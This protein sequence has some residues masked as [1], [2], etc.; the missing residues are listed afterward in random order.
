MNTHPITVTLPAS[1]STPLP[2]TGDEPVKK[3][4]LPVVLPQD[5][6]RAR[7]KTAGLIDAHGICAPHIPPHL[8]PLPLDQKAAIHDWLNKKMISIESTCET[9]FWKAVISL[10]DA[11]CFFWASLPC[12]ETSVIGSTVQNLIRAHAAQSL[13]IYGFLNEEEEVECNDTDIRTW[14][15]GDVKKKDLRKGVK[16]LT[17]HLA[18]S[19]PEELTGRKAAEYLEATYPGKYHEKI[20]DAQIAENVIGN[21]AFRKFHVH[22]DPEQLLMTVAIGD[23]KA[24]P[25]EFIVASK[26]KN[27]SLFRLDDIEIDLTS[28]IQ[29]KSELGSTQAVVDFKTRRVRFTHLDKCDARAYFRYFLVQLKGYLIDEPKEVEKTLFEQIRHMGQTEIAGLLCKSVKNHLPE[30]G[31]SYLLLMVN[32]LAAA[33]NLGAAWDFETI[34]AKVH[35]IAELDR[36]ALNSEGKVI[37]DAIYLDKTPFS[38]IQ[39]ALQ[40]AAFFYL[41]TNHSRAC[42]TE[43]SFQ[44]AMQWQFQRGHTLVVP[45]GIAEGNYPLYEAFLPK[46][47]SSKPEEMQLYPY[48]DCLELPNLYE[49]S[50]SSGPLL[51]FYCLMAHPGFDLQRALDLFFPL[52]L[53]HEQ[54]IPLLEGYLHRHQLFPRWDLKGMKSEEEWCFA[55]AKSG[56]PELCRTAFALWKKNPSVGAGIKLFDE[57]IKTD[58]SS[59]MLLRRQLSK[60][61]G[62]TDCMAF[63]TFIDSSAIAE[64]KDPHG[65]VRPEL[66]AQAVPVLR[67]IPK[68]DKIHKAFLDLLPYENGEGSPLYFA[69]LEAGFTLPK[70]Y[71]PVCQKELLAAFDKGDLERVSY[72]RSLAQKHKIEV[73][74]PQDCALLEQMIVDDLAANKHMDA[75]RHVISL[76]RL[77]PLAEK[78]RAM[79]E[80]IVAKKG[81]EAL[82]TLVRSSLARE[83]YLIWK[84]QFAGDTALAEEI[85]YALPVDEVDALFELSLAILAGSKKNQKIPEDMVVLLL[86]KE[87]PKREEL[88]FAMLRSPSMMKDRGALKNGVAEVAKNI[89]TLEKALQLWQAAKPFQIGVLK[90]FL[91]LPLPKSAFFRKILQDNLLTPAEAVQGVNL[92]IQAGETADMAAIVDELSKF[93]LKEFPEELLKI[94]N[95]GLAKGVLSLSCPLPLSLSDQIT[96][97]IA[98]LMQ[99]GEVDLACDYYDLAQKKGLKVACREV[100]RH[101]C[102]QALEEKQLPLIFLLELMELDLV[103]TA[104]LEGLL[105]VEE[106]E[107][108]AFLALAFR[109]GGS[110]SLKLSLLK[111]IKKV[112]DDLKGEIGSFCSAQISR[113]LETKQLGEARELL[114]WLKANAIPY[115]MPVSDQLQVLAKNYPELREMIVPT[116]PLSEAFPYLPLETQVEQ[117]K[118]FPHYAS[119]VAK[120]LLAK[121]NYSAAFRVL[122]DYNVQEQALWLELLEKYCVFE[123]LI[124]WQKLK[125]LE[126]EPIHLLRKQTLLALAKKKDPSIAD[127]LLNKE[128]LKQLLPEK[129]LI[130]ALP[131]LFLGCPGSG[132]LLRARLIW[133]SYFDKFERAQLLSV[134]LKMH[135]LIIHQSALKNDITLFNEFFTRYTK[136]QLYEAK[137]EMGQ[138]L[139]AFFEKCKKGKIEG[140]EASFI[141]FCSKIKTQGLYGVDPFLILSNLANVYEEDPKFDELLFFLFNSG[142]EKLNGQ[143]SPE[144]V[145][146]S[147]LNL[148]N[149]S[150]QNNLN[151]LIQ[152]IKILDQPKAQWLFPTRKVYEEIYSDM[153]LQ[154]FKTINIT[155]QYPLDAIGELT[156][157]FKTIALLFKVHTFNTVLREMEKTMVALLFRSKKEE[158]VAIAMEEKMIASLLFAFE[159]EKIASHVVHFK[160]QE[161]IVHIVRSIIREK[162]KIESD[163]E[164]KERWLTVIYEKIKNGHRILFD[165]FPL[166]MEEVLYHFLMTCFTTFKPNWTKIAMTIIK[167]GEYLN[168]IKNNEMRESMKFK[169]RYAELKQAEKK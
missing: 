57:I 115:Q 157:R 77:Q 85:Y 66:I 93:N 23:G 95:P 117:L 169:Y 164:L 137:E 34:A 121:Q 96:T 104:H 133:E 3:E 94:F 64:N 25:T 153:V 29:L 149:L 47:L 53:E 48:L 108:A 82:L 71:N 43:S 127:L 74:T 49:L 19:L 92:L 152:I 113:H 2:S 56:V 67:T 147:E 155:S 70:E 146:F 61:E 101:K 51:A 35:E 166:E 140:I 102:V 103:E 161:R 143:A 54:L 16:G 20:A 13:R 135:M 8:P 134:D 83:A 122:E 42:L 50:R 15:Q 150:C 30:E 73:H 168:K 87:H 158:A 24:P 111:Q 138:A 72:I 45:M 52:V 41:F 128:E 27:R 28:D 126:G 76:A 86:N 33:E 40:N 32:S 62:F 31:L 100:V 98:S 114:L 163:P 110:Y 58:L 167:E 10:R 59:A 90:Q 17:S 80:K 136:A 84:K 37:Y 79:L 44:P 68:G 132:G 116:L 123:P 6:L 151:N 46:T 105:K 154:A 139:T 88:L 165:T 22:E 130:Q 107:A 7:W 81:K 65:L 142:L 129:F 144:V 38:Q 125:T 120:E 148:L 160:C 141:D 97:H 119:Q 55:L 78:T 131:H 1:L 89:T 106:K 75:L 69:L 11:I 91:D 109:Q 21:T 124:C 99:S 36:T 162:H 12:S 39:A 14:V 145:R 26:L 63:R 5:A 60:M 9:L 112:E 4:F 159:K 18:R 118:S 156:S